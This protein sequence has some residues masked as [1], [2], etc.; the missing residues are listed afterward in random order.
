MNTK[1]DFVFYRD[2]KNNIYSGGYRINNLFKNLDIPPIYQKGGANSLVLPL[3]LFYTKNDEPINEIEITQKD[4]EISDGLFD[5]LVEFSLKKNKTRKNIKFNNK[6]R[7][8]R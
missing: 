5:R 3:G 4:D 2:E 1:T 7:K 6:T 8:K